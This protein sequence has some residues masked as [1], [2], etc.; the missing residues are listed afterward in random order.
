MR[1]STSMP[2]NPQPCG[3][4]RATPG[5]RIQTRLRI[6]LGYS[7]HVGRLTHIGRRSESALWHSFVVTADPGPKAARRRRACARLSTPMHAQERHARTCSIHTTRVRARTHAHA[8][9]HTHTR[10]R[11]HTH[12]T[13]LQGTVP[14]KRSTE[15]LRV[16]SGSVSARFRAPRTFGRAKS[17]CA[18]L[19]HHHRSGL[20]VETRA[21]HAA[22]TQ[23][24]PHAR[25][26]HTNAQAKSVRNGSATLVLIVTLPAAPH[27]P[28]C[29]VLA[30]CGF[31][32]LSYPIPSYPIL[33]AHLRR[34]CPSA[35]P[36]PARRRGR[37]RRSNPCRKS[38]TPTPPDVTWLDDRI[39]CGGWLANG[40]V[41]V[42]FSRFA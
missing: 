29:V 35:R 26:A 32:I 2:G 9:K 21:S 15:R 19:A 4:P 30:P 16:L 1:L 5:R 25:A 36:C 11:A 40:V 3:Q 33:C 31:P 18:I 41:F 13:T 39:R 12:K 27:P 34:T 14:H 20:H 17:P 10:A 6:S 37:G 38:T 23:A 24:R 8:Y 42:G 22:R 28:T 7:L